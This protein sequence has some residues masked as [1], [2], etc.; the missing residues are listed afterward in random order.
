MRNLVFLILLFSLTAHAQNYFRAAGIRGGLSSGFTYRQHL[1]PELAYEGLLS[2]RRGGLQLTALRQHIQ[3]A[4]FEFSEDFYFLYGF[5]GHLGFNY[6]DNY[7]FM[8]HEYNYSQKRFSPLVGMDGYLGLEY[9]ISAVPIQIGLDLKP[10]F[11]FSI[12]EFFRIVPWDCAFSVKYT[13]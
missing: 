8:F 13:F 10:F 2:F 5:G 9:H 1:D 6:T 12:F 11:E 4:L 7:F 3:P